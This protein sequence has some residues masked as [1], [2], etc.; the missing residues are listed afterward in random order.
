M[1]QRVLSVKAESVA[2]TSA[3]LAESEERATSASRYLPVPAH[4][5]R[6]AANR[7]LSSDVAFPDAT[8]RSCFAFIS[9]HSAA[10]F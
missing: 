3:G 10:S 4:R 9:A 2:V 7:T 6:S 8:S 1:L 5:T